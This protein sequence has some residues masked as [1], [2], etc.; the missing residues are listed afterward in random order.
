MLIRDAIHDALIPAPSGEHVQNSH[1]RLKAGVVSPLLS[2]GGVVAHGPFRQVFL[3]ER[4][5]SVDDYGVPSADER[6]HAPGRRDYI[7]NQ[8][9][10]TF[11]VGLRGENRGR[12]FVKHQTALG[13]GAASRGKDEAD[14]E[15]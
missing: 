4:D 3:R 6:L 9:R 7:P 1:A 2:A 8:A 13:L 12:L 15:D 11:H 5:R 10:A 14:C